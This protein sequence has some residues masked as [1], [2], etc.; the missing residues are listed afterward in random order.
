MAG[1]DA[2]KPKTGFDGKPLDG[3]GDTNEKKKM[4]KAEKKKEEEMVRTCAACVHALARAKCVAALGLTWL[5]ECGRARRI[6]SSA[7][8]LR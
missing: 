6:L 2:L 7:T 1:G 4:S 5:R 8:S 3:S